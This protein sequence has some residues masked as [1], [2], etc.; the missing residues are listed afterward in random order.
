MLPG[1]PQCVFPTEP[2][3]R[4]GLSL[5]RNGCPFSEAS[6]PGSK[7]LTCYFVTPPACLPARSAFG[8][9][10]TTGLPRWRQLLSFSP[11]RLHSPAR[12]AAS[13]VSTPLW[14]FYSLG[15]KAFNRFRRLV[16]R[17]PNSPDFLSLPAAFLLLGLTADH[18][19]RIA[20][21]RRLAIPR[22]SWNLFHYDPNC[23]F[24]Q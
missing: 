14:D 5:A 21:F 1:T 23:L 3:T 22:T 13:S 17:L 16:A 8:S 24:R 10:A 12:P 6:I 18:R 2:A 4:N 9:P 7:V 11:L 20:T 15:I 19:S